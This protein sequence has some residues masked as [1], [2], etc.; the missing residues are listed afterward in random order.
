[1]ALQ[2]DFEMAQATITCTPGVMGGMPCVSGTRVPAELIR[3]YIVDG[4]TNSTIFA[5]YPSLPV[6]AVE[7]VTRWAEQ[8]GLSCTVS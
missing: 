6:G 8:N 1:M 3:K 2:I 5:D 4:E 7:A